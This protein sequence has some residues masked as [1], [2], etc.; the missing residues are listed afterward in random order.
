MARS[1]SGIAAAAALLLVT[2]SVAAQ[3]VAP[4]PA[5]EAAADGKQPAAAA[6]SDGAEAGVAA[7]SQERLDQARVRF[8]RGLKL[9]EE[10][11]FELALIEF[12]R[13]YGI[14]SDYRVLYNIGQVSLQL[15]WYARARSALEEYLKQGAD[16]IAADRRQEVL[17]DLE[18]LAT[19]TAFIALRTN[20][21]GA[22]V[23]VDDKLVGRTP[24]RAPL[25]VDAGEHEL[26]VR[27]E[28]Y[29]SQSERLVLAGG[30]EVQVALDLVSRS[31]AM[32]GVE[33]AVVTPPPPPLPEDQPEPAPRA[34]WLWSGWALTGAM[35]TG[36]VVTW[37]FGDAAARDYHAA[38]DSPDPDPSDVETDQHRARALLATA[39][40]L[41]A[42]AV[43]SGGTTLY[44]TFKHQKHRR[45]ADQV[46]PPRLVLGPQGLQVRGRF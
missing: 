24:L 27:K 9:Y 40:V 8:A 45:S 11:D 34:G 16:G 13:A 15:G 33:P 17:A 41:G 12:E 44:L 1:A 29:T 14:V 30:D 2:G 37:A 5:E 42:L 18:M 39:D 22:G 28:G 38:M 20:V 32:P 25:L 43:V 21:E 6:T 23:F 31:E 36:A 46:A 10:G 35:T 19:R 7:A 4:D 3:P 26:D